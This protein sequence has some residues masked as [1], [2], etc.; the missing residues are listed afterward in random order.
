M[1]NKNISKRKNKTVYNKEGGHSVL[2]NP[3]TRFINQGASLALNIPRK[4]YFTNEEALEEFEKSFDELWDKDRDFLVKAIAYLSDIGRRVSPV[5]GITRLLLKIMDYRMTMAMSSSEKYEEYY[6]KASHDAEETKKYIRWVSNY[7]FDNKRPDKIANS[8]GYFSLRENMSIKK[9]PNWYKNILK[10]KFEKFPALTLKKKKMKHKEIKLADLIKVLHPKPVNDEMSKLYKDIIENNSGAS[11]KDDD[12]ITA[13][14][15]S[16]EKTKEE[17]QQYM[18]DNI[19]T[20]PINALI[21]NLS[22]IN[23]LNVSERDKFIDRLN[24]ILEDESAYKYFNI[25]DLLIPTLVDEEIMSVIDKVFDKFFDIN[26]DIFANINGTVSILLDVSGSMFWDDRH[27]YNVAVKYLTLITK[28]LEQAE[29][30]YDIVLFAST[31]YRDVKEYNKYPESTLKRYKH[32]LTADPPSGGTSLNDAI[33]NVITDDK[34]SDIIV[35]SDEVTHNDNILQYVSAVRL[36]IDNSTV[37]SFLFFNANYVDGKVVA[38]TSKVI[39]VAGMY[40]QIFNTIGIHL[41]PQMLIDYINSKYSFP[42]E[43]ENK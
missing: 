23:E 17:K 21:R 22:Q 4:G 20:M 43:T 12:H 15:S 34:P 18:K 29:I 36:A 40:S 31:L 3:Y 26:K 35:L 24:N 37:N 11:L 2:E 16:T 38:E 19:D 8:L 25:F 7:V 14:L 28:L 33:H 42:W 27:P 13:T 6:F 32:W 30:K 39:R 9:V 10:N 1:L 41:N 5:V